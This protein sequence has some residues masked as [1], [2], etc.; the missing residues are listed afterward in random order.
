[1]SEKRNELA[2][3]PRQSLAVSLTSSKEV[4]VERGRTKLSTKEA[5]AYVHIISGKSKW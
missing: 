1:M 2:T 3:G 5:L 4:K